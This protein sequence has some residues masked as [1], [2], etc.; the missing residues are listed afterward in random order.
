MKKHHFETNSSSIA[1]H[2]TSLQSFIS[3]VVVS[4]R[5]KATMRWYKD[6]SDGEVVCE[7]LMKYEMYLSG[8]G[9]FLTGCEAVYR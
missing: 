6:E 3:E 7:L 8:L 2:S 5:M 1:W 9:G 4:M